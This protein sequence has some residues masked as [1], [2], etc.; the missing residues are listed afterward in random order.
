MQVGNL[1]QRITFQKKTFSGKD[2]SGEDTYTWTDFSPT[3]VRSASI[4]PIKGQELIEA[5]ATHNQTLISIMVRYDPEVSE[6]GTEHR[7]IE[8][9]DSPVTIYA[10]HAVMNHDMRDRWVEFWCSEGLLDQF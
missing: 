6:V 3:I 2:S 9:E 7:I 1:R 8:H 4:K 5:R 10:I